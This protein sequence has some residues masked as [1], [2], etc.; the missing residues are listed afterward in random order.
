MKKIAGLLLLTAAV[1]LTAGCVTSAAPIIG[2]WQTVEPI[3]YDGIN[4]TY[5]VTFE[6]DGTGKMVGTFS[7]PILNSE[8]NYFY[9]ILWEE[10]P[11]G[12]YRYEILPVFTFSEN[13]KTMTD[14]AQYTYSLAEENE[15]FGGVWKEILPGG[16]EI[17]QYFTYIFNEDGTGIETIYENG[18]ESNSSAFHWDEYAENQI[19]IRY[20]S[21]HSNENSKMKTCFE[22]FLT[23]LEDGTLQDTR[24]G[25]ILKRISPS[26]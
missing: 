14:C 5:M 12:T 23:F 1:I 10:T 8:D 6:K 3:Q 21:P 24:Y 17:S 7:D 13:R 18:K 15:M 22:T 19:F 4:Q 26:A 9:P 2:S 20:L 25:D 11:N 16:A